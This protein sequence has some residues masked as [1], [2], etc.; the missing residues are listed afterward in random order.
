[1]GDS[2]RGGGDLDEPGDWRRDDDDLPAVYLI[3]RE[4]VQSNATSTEM[5]D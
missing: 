2:R 1:V 4:L 3:V 5:S